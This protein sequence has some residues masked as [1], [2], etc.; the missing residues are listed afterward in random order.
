MAAGRYDTII[1]QGATFSRTITWKD[2]SGAGINLT[3]YTISGK[4]RRNVNDNTELASFTIVIANQGTYPGRFT[5]SLTAS[6]TSLLPTKTTSDG[7]KDELKLSYDIEAINGT[8]VTRIIEG[9]LTNT[10]Q[11]TR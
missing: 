4:I 11:V 1:E 7:L 6:Q 8:E 3:G 2:P 5:I 9:V 10:P